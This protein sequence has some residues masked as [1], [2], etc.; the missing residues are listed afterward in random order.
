MLLLKIHPYQKSLWVQ[1]GETHNW[2]LD[3]I[4]NKAS[5]NQEIEH[6][7]QNLPLVKN[8]LKH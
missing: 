5:L 4:I 3:L 7:V 8:R 1:M 6:L 2:R